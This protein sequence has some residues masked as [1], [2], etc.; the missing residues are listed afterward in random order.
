MKLRYSKHLDSTLKKPW[1]IFL[2][3]I[4]FTYVFFIVGPLRYYRISYVSVSAFIILF[5]ACAKFFFVCGCSSEIKERRHNLNVDETK[6]ISFSIYYS[7][8]LFIFL[9][10]SNLRN[11]GMSFSAVLSSSFFSRMAETYTDI[12]FKTS[13]PLWILSYTGVFKTIA[14]VGGIAYF[15][16]ISRTSKI[17][18]GLLYV[19]IV[20]N[21]MMFSGAQ[22]QIVDLFIYTL[23]AYFARLVI[24]KKRFKTRTYIIMAIAVIAMLLI[25]GNVIEYRKQLWSSR[26]NADIRSIS[27]GYLDLNN[28]MYRIFP[29]I[30]VNPLVNI[31]GYLTQGYRGLALCLTLPFKWAYGLGSSFSIMNDFVRW[32]D[33]N[34][35]VTQLSYP[36]RMQEVYAINAY[37]NWHTIFPWLASDFTWV[38]AI[39]VVSVFIYY[40]AKSW[41]EINTNGSLISTLVFCHLAIMILYIP[42]NNQLFQTRESIVA[43]III[44]ISWYLFH[45]NEKRRS[46]FNYEEV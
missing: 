6:L 9:I 36:V 26:Y 17:A 19:L 12:T 37:S 10:I 43:S 31:V 3:Y 24:R 41:K 44:I 28:W 33:L 21:V 5:L 22:K 13:L 2:C 11:Y 7:L 27:G 46:V 8:I 4:I 32:F 29:D 23:T 15:D 18:L 34:P 45:G 1:I 42:C 20:V 14:I 25:M 38:G 39:I 30:V 35:D 16:K 40:W